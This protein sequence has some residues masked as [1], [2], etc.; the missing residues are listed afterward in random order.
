[1]RQHRHR[2]DL[3]INSILDVLH[4]HGIE[5]ERKPQGHTHSIY[6]GLNIISS[7]NISISVILEELT[8]FFISIPTKT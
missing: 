4:I 2:F 6:V 1:M 7:I 5:N 3:G 8:F